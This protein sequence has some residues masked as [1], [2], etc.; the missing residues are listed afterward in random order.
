[1]RIPAGLDRCVSVSAHSRRVDPVV[2]EEGRLAM[3]SKIVQ[4][5]V[6]AER[7]R[8]GWRQ[9]AFAALAVLAPATPGV[10]ADIT[11]CN[12]FPRPVFM[13]FAWQERGGGW[14]SRGWRKVETGKCENDPFNLSELKLT[15][16]FYRGETDWYQVERSRRK[17]SWGKTGKSFLVMD[18]AFQFA[19][20]DKAQRN[21]RLEPFIPSMTS[22]SGPVSVRIII[23]RD[24]KGT[25]QISRSLPATP[26]PPRVT[27]PP[28]R[29]ED[30]RSGRR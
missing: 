19:N 21:A 23:N 28:G 25:T 30:D 6:R 24:G 12:E 2:F 16:F 27:A 29:L 13:A 5:I 4:P 22:T 11:V 18:K 20:A 1:V 17:N 15:G 7:A 9:W 26:P 14:V 8:R 10:A 3:T